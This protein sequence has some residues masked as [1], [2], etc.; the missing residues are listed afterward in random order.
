MLSAVA[1]FIINVTNQNLKMLPYLPFQRPR[2]Y[3]ITVLTVARE[4]QDTMM[5]QYILISIGLSEG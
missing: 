1:V 5:N 2:N 3:T 4:K